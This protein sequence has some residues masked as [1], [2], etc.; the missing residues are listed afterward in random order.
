MRRLYDISRS[1]HLRREKSG[2][3]LIEVM[4]VVG[5]LSLIS[6][7]I[8]TLLISSINSYYTLSAITDLSNSASFAADELAD[9]LR[10]ADSAMI[11]YISQIADPATGD[12]YDLIAFPV[13]NGFDIN[14]NTNWQG[15]CAYY[16]F[17]TTEGIN[18]I[19]KYTCTDPSLMA[20][21]FPLTVNLTASNIS[22]FKQ[23][24]SML[25]SFNRTSGAQRVM[26]NSISTVNYTI[27]GSTVSMAFTLTKPVGAVSGAVQ[28]N[29]SLTLNSAA[30]LR[31]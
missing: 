24:G 26:A 22:L 10:Q 8:F 29:V 12:S 17:Q 7:A 28:R 1:L 30:T 20:A 5:L 19:R 6:A 2:F 14:G 27:T 23:D 9:D 25:M 31:N 18:Q 21:D 3:T 11:T 15:A 4:I 13:T 16:P